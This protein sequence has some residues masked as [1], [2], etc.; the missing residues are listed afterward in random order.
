MFGFEKDAKE[1]ELESKMISITTEPL[2][3][4]VDLQFST[5]EFVGYNGNSGDMKTSLLQ[6]NT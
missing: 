5:T 3:G 1:T 6:T 2:K 4:E